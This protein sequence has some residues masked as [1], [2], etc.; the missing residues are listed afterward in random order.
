MGKLLELVLLSSIGEC[1]CVTMEL[2]NNTI[3]Y[4][5]MCYIVI[6]MQPWRKLGSL[7]LQI[8]HC[9][10]ILIAQH[11]RVSLMNYLIISPQLTQTLILKPLVDMMMN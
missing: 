8:I 10:K 6:G 1:T 5:H 7:M 4:V 11:I 2:Y 9:W 3:T